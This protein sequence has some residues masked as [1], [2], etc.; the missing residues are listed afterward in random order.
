MAAEAPEVH[1]GAH[2]KFDAGFL[3]QKVGP[4]PLWVWLAA[5]IAI[6]YFLNRQNNQTPADSSAAIDPATGET[7]AAELGAATQQLADSQTGQ[8]GIAGGFATDQAWATAAVN[9]L[10]GLGIDATEASNAVRKYI[11]SQ[12]LTEK[13][14]ADVNLAIQGIGAPP[15]VH[16]TTP[17]PPG[18]GPG[19]GPGPGGGGGSSKPSHAPTGVTASKVTTSSARIDWGRLENATSYRV[20]VWTGNQTLDKTSKDNHEAFSGLKPGTRYNVHVAGA[21]S[22]GQGPWSETVNFTTNK[23][24]SKR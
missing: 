13:E 16:V 11:A 6:W 1:P 7:Y 17:A 10:V 19:P 23:V 2:P 12:P 4:L 20:R 18:G 24:A 3:K 21:S 9:Y 14:Q 22:A 5:G 8:T 15:T